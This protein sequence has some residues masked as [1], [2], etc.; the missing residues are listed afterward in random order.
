[1]KRRRVY[2]EVSLIFQWRGVLEI[3][4]AMLIE[5][6]V[7]LSIN[8]F[9]FSDYFDKFADEISIYPAIVL[10]KNVNGFKLIHNLVS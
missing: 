4:K 7:A 5:E 2:L 10:N 6:A 1:M 9:D 8:S 3:I